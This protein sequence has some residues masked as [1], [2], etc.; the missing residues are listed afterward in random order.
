MQY[1]E[2]MSAKITI[3]LFRSETKH[4]YNEKLIYT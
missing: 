3:S 2:I 1:E 4:A